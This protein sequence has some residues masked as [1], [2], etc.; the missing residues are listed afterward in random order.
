MSELSVGTRLII[1][2]LAYGKEY[3]KKWILERWGCFGTFDENN[4]ECT[5]YGCSVKYECEEKKEREE[6]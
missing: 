5:F 3:V 1:L 6:T 4:L 2:K